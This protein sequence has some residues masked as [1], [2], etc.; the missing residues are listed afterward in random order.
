MH[1][2]VAIYSGYSDTGIDAIFNVS[3]HCVSQCIAV[4]GCVDLNNMTYILIILKVQVILL[5]WQCN[6]KESWSVL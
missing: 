6:R 1:R 4:I 3:I 2:R 5:S